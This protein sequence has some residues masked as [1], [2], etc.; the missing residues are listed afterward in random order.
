MGCAA[1]VE[2]LRSVAPSPAPSSSQRSRWPWASPKRSTGIRKHFTREEKRLLRKYLP[3]LTVS[4]VSNAGHRAIAGEHWRAAYRDG[5]ASGTSKRSTSSWGR[6][7]T[8]PP[9][10]SSLT[11]LYDA[12][13]SFLETHSPDVTFVFRASMHV[14]SKVLIHISA[15]LR[16][17]LA[18][19]NFVDK[20]VALTKTHLQVGVKLEHFAPLA[21]AL[22]F[23]MEQSSGELWTPDVADAWRHL[24]VHCSAVLMVELKRATEQRARLR[25]RERKGNDAS[26]PE[27]APTTDDLYVPP[28]NMSIREHSSDEGTTGRKSSSDR[29]GATVPPSSQPSWTRLPTGPSA[30]QLGRSP[31]GSSLQK[32]TVSK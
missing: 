18:A 11:L 7:S 2:P 1:S 25:K 13:H 10:G 3:R 14:R 17:L 20:A 31:S 22:F 23:A 21:D 19:D 12:F 6:D 16:S 28:R 4:G 8:G 26:S 5:A 29:T 32:L 27:T 9:T 24:Y 30:A 15:G